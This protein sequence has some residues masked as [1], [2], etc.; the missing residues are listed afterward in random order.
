MKLRQQ[1]DKL[2]YELSVDIIS[3]KTTIKISYYALVYDKIHMFPIHLELLALKLLQEFKDLDCEPLQI[4]L[5]WLLKLEEDKNKA[6][7]AFQH[8]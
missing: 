3:V 7:K 4:R 2:Y 1:H 8:K 5:N 6:Y